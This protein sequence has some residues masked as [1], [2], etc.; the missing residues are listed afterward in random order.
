MPTPIDNLTPNSSY[1][2]MV[3][4]VSDCIKIEM[5]VGNPQQK[6]IAMC[7]KMCEEKTGKKIP[8]RK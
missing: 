5:E 7:I 6:A 3:D 1:K 4:A 8:T 2:E